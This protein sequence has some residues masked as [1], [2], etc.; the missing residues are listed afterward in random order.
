MPRI[1]LYYPFIHFRDEEWLKL[2][3]LYWSNMGRIVPHGHRL[4]DSRV[5]RQL[6]DELG[7]VVNINPAEGARRIAPVF[8]E[9]L[10]EHGP[11]LQKR[12]GVSARHPYRGSS[13]RPVL[14][15]RA[16]AGR[17]EQLEEPPSTWFS[18]GRPPNKKDHWR[19]RGDL[20]YIAI[21]KIDPRLVFRLVRMDLV[22]VIETDRRWS[23]WLGMHPLLAAVYMTALAEELADINQFEPVADNAV[24]HVAVSGWSVPRLV[25]VLLGETSSL[26]TTGPLKAPRPSAG[27]V[28]DML[29]ILAIKSVVPQNLDAVP[30]EKFIKIR[31]QYG[32]ELVAFRERLEQVGTSLGAVGSVKDATALQVHLEAAYQELLRP[33]LDRLRKDL[34]TFGLDTVSAV[35]NVRVALPLA[36]TSLAELAKLPIPGG[37]VVAAGG[38]VAFSF[39]EVLRAMR[40]KAQQQVE[41]SPAAYLLHLQEGLQP[42]NI[43]KQVRR[44]IRTFLTGF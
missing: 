33:D 17:S 30:I 40:R 16:I 36:A 39:V 2:A 8:W 3:A 32:D 15:E 18:S 44:V 21:E 10:K 28:P 1:G 5:V 11:A 4:H 37:P 42:V 31:R 13:E 14:I 35:F 29:G 7:F 34:N 41:S 26:E 25:Q 9:A 38:A 24:S 23:P 12:Y 20:A 19:R 43:V 6:S 27:E 22:E